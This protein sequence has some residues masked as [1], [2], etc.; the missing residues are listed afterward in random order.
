MIA[1]T[2]HPDNQQPEIDIQVKPEQRI[3]EVL[4]ILKVNGVISFR[5]PEAGISVKSWRKNTYIN[6]YLT[7]KQ[8]GIWQGDILRI[9]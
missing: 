1:L 6:P 7:F 3:K 2:I 5:D 9:E 4:D 8:A